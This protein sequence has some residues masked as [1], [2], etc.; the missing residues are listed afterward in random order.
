MHTELVFLHFLSFQNKQRFL[1]QETIPVRGIPKKYFIKPPPFPV[2]AI[3]KAGSPTEFGSDMQTYP[4]H[5]VTDGEIY[6]DGNI[7]VEAL[8]NLH[9][10]GTFRRDMAQFFLPDHMEKLRKKNGSFRRC[11]FD[12]GSALFPERE[13]G[14][15]A[16]GNRTP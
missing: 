13:N 14:S 11:P 8:H 9:L 2:C 15:S 3:M 6:E 4:V 12:G 16:D 5:P 10:E 1:R 7:A